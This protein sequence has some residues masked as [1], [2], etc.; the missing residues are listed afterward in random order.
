M[1]RSLD[2]LFARAQGRRFDGEAVSRAEDE[3]LSPLRRRMRHAME[4]VVAWFTEY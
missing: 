3:V 1:R 2:D 4:R